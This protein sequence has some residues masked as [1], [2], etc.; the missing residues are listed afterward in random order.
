[1]KIIEKKQA[2]SLLVA[3]L[4]GAFWLFAIRFV[5]IQKVEVHYHANFA[6]FIDGE[7]EKFDNFTFYEEVASCGGDAINDPKTRAHMH[8][9]INH[10]V[11]VH[12]NA[13][14][15]GHFFANLGYATG[16]TL[17]KTVNDTYIENDSTEIRYFL[18]G[19]EI[20]TI[21]NR[22]IRSED[23]LLISVGD[24]TGTDLQSE[25]DEITK[26]AGEYNNR[27]DP[28]NCSG[29]KPFTLGERFKAAVGIF[30]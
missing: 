13:A 2:V 23:A 28:S 16:D 8:D 12:D 24:A 4:F 22:T 14:T 5:T 19:E 1:M 21:A 10:I 11:H 30:D 25:Y 20:D 7:R 18:N 15:W 9:D 3:F 29:G 6:V 26:D 17:L 27:D